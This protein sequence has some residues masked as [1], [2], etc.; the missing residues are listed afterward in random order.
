MSDD[1]D[2]FDAVDPTDTI[3][4]ML[5]AAIQ[6]G[7]P[8]YNS[9]DARGCFDI[10]AAV[11]RMLLR[12]VQGGEDE[13]TALRDALQEAALEPDVNEQAWIMR[14]AFDRILG[15]EEEE[16]EEGKDEGFENLN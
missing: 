9:G 14:R 12:V 7:A 15:E 2:E 5:A 1:F 16:E 10:Y 13:T 8:V 3:R 11:A 4:T 6:V